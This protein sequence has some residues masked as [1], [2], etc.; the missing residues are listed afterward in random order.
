MQYQIG[1]GYRVSKQVSFQ[2]GVIVGNRNFD[3]RKDQFAYFGPSINEKYITGATADISLVEI[4]L[5]LRYQFSDR[6]NYGLFFTASL[7]SVFMS[8]ENY[9]IR[10]ENAGV[11]SY[12]DQNFS[13]TKSV[14]SLFT[15][16]VGYQ[17]PISKTFTISAEPY[18]QLPFKVIGEGGS[19]I[20]SVGLSIGGRYNFLRRKK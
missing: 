5:G 20:S 1:I 11:V 10:L 17:Y 2:T 7:S 16:S 18:L 4:P 3:L 15:L 9:K 14:L 19:K 8:K 13:N 12:D 6:D